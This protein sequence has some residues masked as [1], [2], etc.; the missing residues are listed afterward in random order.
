MIY[1]DFSAQGGIVSNRFLGD[2]ERIAVMIRQERP[3]KD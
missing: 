1:R 2:L 3:N